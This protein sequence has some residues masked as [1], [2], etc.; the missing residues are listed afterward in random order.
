MI[1]QLQRG[2]ST[3]QG[4][5]GIL[6]LPGAEKSWSSLELPDRGNQVGKS[7]I[8]PGIYKATL[9]WSPHFKQQLYHLEDKDGRQA[10]EIHAAN[11][12]G[13]TTMGWKC[14][15]LGCIALGMWTDHVIINKEGRQQK[16]L[17]HSK[18]ALQEFMAATGGADLEIEIT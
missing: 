16:A 12:A 13:D 2:I 18:Q 11:Y 7:R 1:V 9:R 10:I 15:L 4:T 8:L 5:F 6:S 17:L 14:E 3:D